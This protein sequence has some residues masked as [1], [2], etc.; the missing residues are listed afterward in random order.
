MP[1][2]LQLKLNYRSFSHQIKRIRNHLLLDIGDANVPSRE[3]MGKEKKV[4]NGSIL[5]TQMTKI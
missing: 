2:K 4:D 3:K 1:E 5:D